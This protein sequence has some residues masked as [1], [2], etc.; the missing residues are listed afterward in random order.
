MLEGKELTDD[1]G[2]H[3]GSIASCGL[4]AF[5]QLLYFPDLDVLLRLIL[6]GRCRT[7]IVK[8][9]PTLM[10]K[11]WYKVELKENKKLCAGETALS[12]MRWTQDDQP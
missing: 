1:E 12:R 9:W 8:R 5:D 2:D 10:A 6:L 3:R 7:H 11:E 4:E